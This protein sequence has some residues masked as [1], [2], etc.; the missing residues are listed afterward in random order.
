MSTIYGLLGIEDRD[1]TVDNAGQ[2]A[3]YEATQQILDRHNADVQAAL[4]ALVGETTTIYQ[5]LY[6]LPGGGQM[7]KS[8]RL[9]RPGAVKPLGSYT[10][11]YD[12]EDFRDQLAWDDV[13][14]AY[15]SLA[16]YNVALQNITMR[17][18]N[19]VR[20]EVLRHLLNPTNAT[21]ADEIHGNLTVRRLANTDSTTYPPVIGSDTGADDNHYLASG[22]ATASIS[23]TNNP[24][25]TVREEL[26]E[27][28]GQGEPIMFINNAERAK[29]EALPD[30]IPVSVPQVNEG[31]STPTVTGAPTNVPGRVIGRVNDV[32]V[33][34]WRWMPATY[35]FTVDLMQPAPLT[36]RID[37]P[38]SIK[39][40]G[41]LELVAEQMEFPLS[42]SFWRCREGYGVSNRLNGVAMKF[43]TGSYDSP[44]IY[45]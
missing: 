20:F 31:T 1:T 12:L 27:H 18:L 17:H 39:G 42:E 15:M 33:D 19:T 44:T 38:T 23:S 36:K 35:S 6:Y 4:S 11:A 40:R 25:P 30:F 32:W 37:V 5:E 14:L 26:E 41:I 7:Q 28:F 9:T 29:I 24:F 21:F 45:A 43:T 22:Y 34:E 16:K 10:V 3:V 2:R 13:A 8:T